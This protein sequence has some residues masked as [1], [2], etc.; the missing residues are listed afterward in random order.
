MAHAES[1][2]QTMLAPGHFI[3][4]AQ[5]TCTAGG[6]EVG[7]WL[8]RGTRQEPHGH[9][10]A[11]LVFV[12]GGD[13]FTEAGGE[14]GQAG[15]P[16]VY[17]PAGTEHGDHLVSGAGCFLSISLRP[18]LDLAPGELPLEPVQI[19]ETRAQMLARRI[20]RELLAEAEP[21]LIE[22]LCLDLVATISPRPAGR[23]AGPDRWLERAREALSHEVGQG[24]AVGALAQALGIH[25]AHLT[26]RFREAFG[27][28]PGEYRRAWRLGLA[29]RRIAARRHSLAEIALDC[30]FVDQSHL[31]NQFLRAY[32]V[33]PGRYRSLLAA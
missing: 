33:S 17:N 30:G 32:G 13:Y 27:A 4:A 11:H 7:Q 24:P 10:A 21:D 20:L 12:F 28:T 2:R 1:F 29:A 3:G 8:A 16:L 19:G 26:R 5:R 9:D 15:T 6:F 22:S 18:E 25:P 23:S 31:T 14:P